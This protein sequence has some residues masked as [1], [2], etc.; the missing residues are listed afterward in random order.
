MALLPAETL[1]L[2]HGDALDTDLVER[3]LHLVELEGLYDC[4]NLLHWVPPCRH[5]KRPGANRQALH[6]PLSMS[7]ATMLRVSQPQAS[8]NR[9]ARKQ[10]FLPKIG[11]RCPLARQHR[12]ARGWASDA[13]AS[14][15]NSGR[16]LVGDVGLGGE[17]DR[18]GLGVPISGGT[19]HELP[20][21]IV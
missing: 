5:H 11:S 3:F 15:S 9:A 12:A 18:V 14:A 16:C 2:G 10:A 4:F 7:R 8:P 17:E 1:G 6:G 19:R 13:G 20:A 21:I